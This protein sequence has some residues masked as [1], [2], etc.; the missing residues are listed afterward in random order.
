MGGIIGGWLLHSNRNREVL[1]RHAGR[2]SSILLYIHY[3]RQIPELRSSWSSEEY[4]GAVGSVREGFSGEYSVDSG[5]VYRHYGLEEGC[6]RIGISAGCVDRYRD[7][8]IDCWCWGIYLYRLK[9]ASVG[10]SGSGE[11]W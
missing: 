10:E 5:R 9:R 6:S 11:A 3:C 8:R 2:L 1:C 7:L 4:V